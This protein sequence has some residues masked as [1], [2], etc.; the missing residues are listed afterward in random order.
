MPEY[1][2]TPT[3]IS[4]VAEK[5]LRMLQ[6][7][8]EVKVNQ[9]NAIQEEFKRIDNKTWPEDGYMDL[10]MNFLSSKAKDEDTE[11][12][13]ELFKTYKQEKIDILNG[14]IKNVQT[15]EKEIIS[16]LKLLARNKGAGYIESLSQLLKTTGQEPAAVKKVQQLFDKVVI[17]TP[18]NKKTS[19][20]T[21]TPIKQPLVAP[22]LKH[23]SNGSH[24][25]QETVSPNGEK[26]EVEFMGFVN[27]N[28]D[29][30]IAP[31]PTSN[32]EELMVALRLKYPELSIE[33]GWYPFSMR[34]THEAGGPYKR[35]ATLH[36]VEQNKD[37]IAQADL[38]ATSL[39]EY[40][41]RI[42]EAIRRSKEDETKA[43]KEK[44]ISNL[45]VE[46]KQEYDTLVT[47][48]D[49]TRYSVSNPYNNLYGESIAS[50]EAPNIYLKEHG[51]HKPFHAIETG[52]LPLPIP[53]APFGP[54][55]NTLR[56][57]PSSSSSPP[58]ASAPIGSLPNTGNTSPPSLPTQNY[59]IDESIQKLTDEKKN[60]VNLLIQEIKNEIK[61]GIYP[62]IAR[63]R[64]KV[65]ALTALNDDK[66]TVDDALR[67]PNVI[68]GII[69][70]RTLNAIKKYKAYDEAIVIL[71]K[72]KESKPN[73]GQNS[74]LTL[75][76]DQIYKI[77]ELIEKLQ[78]EINRGFFPNTKKKLD[79]IK[80]LT[81]LKTSTLS[82]LEAVN[83]VEKDFVK[84][85]TEKSRTADLLHE[86]KNTSPKTH[87]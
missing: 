9:N 32:Y 42:Q 11:K 73:E 46:E 17:P 39:F 31:K 87:K 34:T 19:Q 52:P 54:L 65:E 10:L 86:L 14:L 84:V 16:E 75:S 53:S 27:K 30:T 67:K 81:E 60:N 5:L 77:N 24:P 80:A 18:P 47:I 55:P 71:N 35:V 20:E 63:K 69:S 82:V 13:L 4:R 3:G 59:K 6:L 49:S 36:S 1:E 7:Q 79:K 33:K 43:E 15:P 61:R 12:L 37:V 78:K 44:K 29:F 21:V 26:M 83:Q 50:Q 74:G 56:T 48:A 8:R 2:N 22:E 76:P 64:E 72:R 57:I 85:T 28:G 23:F 40:E 66:L 25:W 41:E 51:E 38:I 70:S 58:I 45:S 68:K 62:N